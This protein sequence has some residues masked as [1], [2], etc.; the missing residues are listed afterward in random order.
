[1]SRYRRASLSKTVT[2]E[3]TRIYNAASRLNL[4]AT[5]RVERSEHPSQAHGKRTDDYE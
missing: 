1:M 5:L 4:L 3:A 2:D